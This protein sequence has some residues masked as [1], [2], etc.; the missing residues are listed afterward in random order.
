MAL[1]PLEAADAP[2]KS[3]AGANAGYPA[4]DQSPASANSERQQHQS[5]MSSTTA[6]PSSSPSASVVGTAT[7]AASSVGVLS[8]DH[9]VPSHASAQTPPL[10]DAE[11]DSQRATHTIRLSA[12]R[13]N[14][15]IVE[16][17]ASRQRCSV[18]VVVKADGYGHGAVETAVHLADYCGADAFA[19]ATLEEGIA[20]RRA[21]SLPAAAA[22]GGVGPAHPA[23]AAAPAP[24]GSVGVE[25]GMM[26]SSGAAAAGPMVG[27]AA[28][29]GS[30][31]PSRRTSEMNPAAAAAAAAPLPVSVA[32]GIAELF[33]PP[34]P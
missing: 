27:A 4:G 22:G 19:V 12:L 16:D 31:P 23:A 30:L 5:Q 25:F 26:P 32:P 11:Q 14:Y 28:L 10:I 7:T 34:S 29:A 13:H 24:V 33:R 3:S 20:L 9:T 17:A 21:L 8:A 2:P 18:I 15:A 1:D 6:L